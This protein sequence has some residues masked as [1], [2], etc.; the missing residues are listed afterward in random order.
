MSKTIILE[1]AGA[2]AEAAKTINHLAITLNNLRNSA[3]LSTEQKEVLMGI[4]ED[5]IEASKGQQVMAELALSYSREC[6]S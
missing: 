1:M 5:A 3:A 6:A 2:A 4:I